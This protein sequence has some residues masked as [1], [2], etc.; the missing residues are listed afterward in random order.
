MK[1]LVFPFAI[2]DN[3]SIGTTHTY[4]EIVR[5]QVIDA[6]MTNQG[7]RL[8]RAEYGCDIQAALFDP[9]DELVRADAG[10]YILQRLQRYTPRAVVI[11]VTIKSPDNEQG[12]VYVD[13][14]YRPSVF[15][16]N[17]TLSVP[18]SSEYINRSLGG[19]L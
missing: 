16:G 3:R 8:Y 9:S 4:E 13:I 18:I 14:V 17:Q 11:S 7:E 5:G 10:N 1:T 2:S 12:V 15:Q 6:L 19:R